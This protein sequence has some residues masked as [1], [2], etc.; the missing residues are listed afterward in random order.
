MGPPDE[1]LDGV[2]R[3]RGE[4]EGEPVLVIALHG[5][6]GTDRRFIDQL[7]FPRHVRLR[8]LRGPIAEGEGFAWFVFHFGFDRAVAQMRALLPRLVASIA[9]ERRPGER[10]VVTGFSQGGMLAYALAARHPDA[11]DGALPISAA[12]LDDFA[13]TAARARRMPRLRAVH[14]RSD[15]VIAIEEGR[16]SAE[17]LRRLGA[18][19]AIREVPGATHWIG[20]PMREAVVDALR[21]LIDE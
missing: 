15:E 1:P 18:D 13:P 10:V 2:T 5:R 8:S 3:A 11:I 17:R 4:G 12:L 20:A 7:A 21:E 9:A 16:R 6:G 19:A 14:G